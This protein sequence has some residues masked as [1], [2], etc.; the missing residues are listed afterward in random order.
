VVRNDGRH[1]HRCLRIRDDLHRQKA[2][3]SFLRSSPRSILGL[4]QPFEDQVRVWTPPWMQAE[5][6]ARS[7]M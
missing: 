1:S 3:T 2:Q 7:G 5:S 4:A 6:W